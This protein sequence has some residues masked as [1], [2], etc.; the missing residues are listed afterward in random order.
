MTIPYWDARSNKCL[1]EIYNPWKNKCK[2]RWSYQFA[3]TDR[4]NDPDWI[5]MSGSECSTSAIAALLYGW[6]TRC[7]I[8][9]GSTSARERLRSSFLRRSQQTCL[10]QKTRSIYIHEKDWKE[11]VFCLL[12]LLFEW[13]P[14]ELFMAHARRSFI[15]AAALTP[16]ALLA[17]Q[18][19]ANDYHEMQSVWIC[20][21]ANV[22]S[23]CSCLCWYWL[24]IS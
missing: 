12:F 2:I 16:L 5:I 10:H 13:G 14:P 19:A 3:H 8:L 7:H 15:T 9:K 22:S 1:S 23:R 20:C 18:D 24:R 21:L 6:C 4:F 11:D 17:L